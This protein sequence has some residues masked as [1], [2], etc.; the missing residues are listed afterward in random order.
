LSV[1]SQIPKT[2]KTANVKS[3]D[4]GITALQSNANDVVGNRYN[5]LNSG[6]IVGV[7]G[8][9]IKVAKYKYP[10]KTTP[11]SGQQDASSNVIKL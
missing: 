10:H 11:I 8:Q 7:G 2:N 9:A 5:S 3:H 6:E 4:N 1:G